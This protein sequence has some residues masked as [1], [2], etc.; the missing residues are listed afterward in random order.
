MY[1][2]DS[3]RGNFSYK[4]VAE[5]QHEGF[6]HHD[7]NTSSLD[8]VAVG[9]VDNVL[10]EV[11]G[12]VLYISRTSTNFLEPNN[13]MATGESPHKTTPP[14]VGLDVSMAPKERSDIP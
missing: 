8:V 10:G 11:L 5:V 12:K 14:L 3:S 13:I 6:L 7:R 4:D 1:L 2:K 9:G